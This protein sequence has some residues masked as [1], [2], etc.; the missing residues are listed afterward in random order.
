MRSREFEVVKVE[1]LR[2]VQ[3][4][5]GQGRAVRALSSTTA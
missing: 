3:G 5:V 1:Q 4:S 2:A